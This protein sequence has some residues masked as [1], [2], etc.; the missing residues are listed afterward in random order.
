[1]AT[2]N[3]FPPQRHLA[4]SFQRHSTGRQSSPARGSSPPTANPTDWKPSFCDSPMLSAQELLMGC[5]AISWQSALETRTGSKYLA[6]AH[7]GNRTFTLTTLLEP[8]CLGLV[9]LGPMSRF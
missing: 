5:Y 9:S 2:P 1:M 8:S 4:H 3:R 6:M 7:S